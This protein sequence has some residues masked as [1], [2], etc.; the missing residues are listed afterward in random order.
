MWLFYHSKNL[1]AIKIHI[2]KSDEIILLKKALQTQGFV[3]INRK[4]SKCTIDMTQIVLY[5][6]CASQSL[7]QDIVIDKKSN[8]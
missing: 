2:K 8:L 5:N 7:T 6:V 1:F 4:S 3:V